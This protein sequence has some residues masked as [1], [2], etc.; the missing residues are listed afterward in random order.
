MTTTLLTIVLGVAV[1]FCARGKAA[2]REENAEEA[3]RDGW[4]LRIAQD[5]MNIGAHEALGDSLRR[6]GRLEEARDAYLAALAARADESLLSTTRAKLRHTDDDLRDRAEGRTGK[7]PY[8]AEFAFCRRCG[9]PN[10]PH[11]RACDTC[12]GTLAYD[13]FWEALR[14]REVQRA[15]WESVAVL[16]VL[17]LCLHIFF[18]LPTLVQGSV[19]LSTIIVMGWRF[20][21][22][23]EGRRG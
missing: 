11:V 9:T 18:F 21:R 4:R 2:R 16:C 10:P 13:T 6:A 20:L 12:G 22:A 14:D 8:S 1:W 3:R 15:T 17:G 5:P 23:L 19:A 7:V